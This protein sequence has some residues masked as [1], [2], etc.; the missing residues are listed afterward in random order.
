MTVLVQMR[1]K[2]PDVGGSRPGGTCSPPG[3]STRRLKDCLEHI[4]GQPAPPISGDPAHRT[5]NV[6]FISVG[7]MSHWK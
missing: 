6:P 4:A 1:V 3:V 7:W 5:M 2:V